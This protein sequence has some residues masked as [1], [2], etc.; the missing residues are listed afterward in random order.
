MS[1][2]VLGKWWDSIRKIPKSYWG[3][4]KEALSDG[5]FS[6]VRLNGRNFIA[7]GR[8]VAQ[9]ETAVTLTGF[10]Y[11]IS[12]YQNFNGHQSP[13]RNFAKSL[14]S[15]RLKLLASLPCRSPTSNKPQNASGSFWLH[16]NPEKRA[17][18]RGRKRAASPSRHP[19]SVRTSPRV[20]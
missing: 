19:S 16:R 13:L 20:N 14:L 9:L 1:T 12:T 15:I 3:P 6:S 2:N 17:S 5:R 4:E 8:W 11:D 10:L 18:P 7:N